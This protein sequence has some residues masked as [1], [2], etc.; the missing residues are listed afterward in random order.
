MVEPVGFMEAW[1]AQFPESEPPCMDLNSLGGIEQELNNCKSSIRHL[2]KEVNKERFRMIYLQ[3]LMAKERKSYD[4]QRWGFR[5]APGASEGDPPAGPE[6]SQALREEM[7]RSMQLPEREADGVPPANTP[8]GGLP[9]PHPEPETPDIPVGVGSVAV[10]RSNFE[11]I[12]RANSQSAADGRGLSVVPGGPDKPFYVNVEYHHEKGLVKVNDRD[13]SE[14]ISTLGCQA[15]QMERKRSLPSYPG[16]LSAAVADMGRSFHRGRSVEAPG[17]GFSSE[18]SYD[19]LSARPGGGGGGAEPHR[20]GAPPECQ[21]YTS[22]YVGGLMADRDARVVHI[23]SGEGEEEE[24]EEDGRRLTWPRRSYSPGSCEDVVGGYTP[25]C[26]SNENLTSS[27][28]D[29][30]SGPSSHVSP[31]PTSCPPMYREKSRSPSQQS[32][33]SGSPPAPLSLKRLQQQQ[34]LASEAAAARHRRPT[35][36]GASD[37]DSTTSSRTSHDNSIQ[38]DLGRTTTPITHRAFL[39]CCVVVHT[40][41]WGTTI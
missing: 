7:T 40:C 14:R 22:V 1:R 23:R 18:S 17:C 36:I 35:R 28:E 37:G 5:K 27:E 24:E 33:E 4:G 2:E 26:S 16:N 20:P 38:G 12:K 30:S 39:Q 15:M 34:A 19:D 8:R 25:D 6:S 29:F 41:M 32:L 31:S 21:P 9:P 11:R 3:T 10:L 13:V